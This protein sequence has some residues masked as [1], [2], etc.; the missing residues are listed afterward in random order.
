MSR[1]RSPGRT[2]ASSQMRATMYGW[3]IVWPQPIWMG[4]SS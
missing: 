3:E 1:T 2:A 4:M